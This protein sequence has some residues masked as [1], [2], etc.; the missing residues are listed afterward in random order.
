MHEFS[1]DAALYLPLRGARRIVG[2][3][4][5]LPDVQG[6][7]FAPDQQNLLE[8]F[9]NQTALAIERTVS[10][11]TAEAARMQMQTEEM[12]SSLLSAV[13]HDLRTPLASIT[14]AASTLRVQGEKLP[15][16]TREDLLDSISKEAERLGRLVG[17]L[18][19]MTRLETG[20]EIRRDLYPLEEIVGT[21]LQ[22][23]EQQSAGRQILTTLPDNLPLVYVDDVLF[24][25]VIVNL[26]E[27]AV[28]YSPAE[29]PIEVVAEA[30]EDS[31]TL[32]VRDRGEGF[33]EGEEQR[34]FEKF[35]RGK[36]EGVRGAGLGL[37]ICRAIVTAHRG[38]I[39]ALNRPGGGAILRVRLPL[40]SAR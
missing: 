23:M 26:L 16:E 28:K 11:N 2:V 18:L 14:G 34:V 6:R 38:T 9:A 36:P 32:E 12:R 39:E 35:Y 30:S 5:V 17:N 20:V 13:S 8:L 25:Q 22:R 3:M 27:N 4:C 15:P 33:A 19:D 24:G 10:Q 40:E 37:A 7:V 21:A 31:V 29:T 1:K